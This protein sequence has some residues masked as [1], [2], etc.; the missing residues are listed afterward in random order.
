MSSRSFIIAFC[1]AAI[2]FAGI[3]WL[4]ASPPTEWSKAADDSSRLAI[5]WT[6]GDPEVAHRMTLMYGHA[7][8]RQGWFDEVLL[9]V[10]GPSQRLL[11][12]DK[13][14]QAYI[15]RLR[16]AGVVVEACLACADSYGIADDLREL[17][18]E[19]KYMGKPLSDLLKDDQWKV[20]T[21]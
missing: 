13:D 6:S 12:A 14:V 2:L 7:A 16:E 3:K 10:W 11:V 18:L 1:S 9:V 8:K 4:T 15:D 17:G 21:F 5:V 19:V 20:L